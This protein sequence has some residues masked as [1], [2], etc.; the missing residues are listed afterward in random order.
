MAAPLSTS[1]RV[2]ALIACLRTARDRH[3]VGGGCTEEDLRATEERLGH[4][5]PLAFRLFLQR[6][7]GGIYYLRHEIF[8][9]RRVMVHDI[10]MVPDLLSF[11]QWLAAAAPDGWLPIHRT[12]GRMHAIRLGGEEPAPVRAL[13][14]GGPTYP[15]FATFLE[16]LIQNQT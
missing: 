1:A 4:A 8:G 3:I 10:E 9:A 16:S 7:G 11:R 14:P 6:Q 12:E 13:E 2:D 15:D 5:L